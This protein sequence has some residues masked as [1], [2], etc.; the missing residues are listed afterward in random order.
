MIKEGDAAPDFS[1][2][3]AE[4]NEVKLSDLRGQKVVLYF[5][6]KD[7]TPGCT[8]EACSFRDSFHELEE[9]KIKVLGVS[10][11]N[12]ESH[13][14]FAGKYSLPFTLLSDTDHQV[15]DAY[16]VYGEREFMGKKYMGLA[17]KT[18][19]IDEAGKI[20]KI[21]DKVNVEEHAGEVM[22]AFAA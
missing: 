2:H 18:F 17:R 7:D 4:G 8:K 3:D 21:F 20:K 12:E 9:K 6:P 13:Q 14:K 19:L 15:S 10:L 1:A 11:D 16:G 5:Y 22:D